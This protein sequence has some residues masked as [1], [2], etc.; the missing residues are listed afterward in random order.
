MAGNGS[1]IGGTRDTLL[2]EL[3]RKIGQAAANDAA[4]AVLDQL[5]HER[6][7]FNAALLATRCEFDAELTA[8]KQELAAAQAQLARLQA[9]DHAVAMPR[10]ETTTLH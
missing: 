3:G 7:A 6:E 4:D 8:L 1:S 2:Y 9:I 10:D 5:R